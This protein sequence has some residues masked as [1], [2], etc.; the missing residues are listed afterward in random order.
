M[1]GEKVS[2][3]WKRRLIFLVSGLC[4]SWTVDLMVPGIT[5]A[6]HL[7]AVVLLGLGAVAINKGWDIE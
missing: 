7:I 6:K 2:S 5:F 1:R 3:V 4:F